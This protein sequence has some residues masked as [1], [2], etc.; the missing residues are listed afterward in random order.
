MTYNKLHDVMDFVF[1]VTDSPRSVL[2]LDD[3]LDKI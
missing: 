1:V 3:V 2:Q